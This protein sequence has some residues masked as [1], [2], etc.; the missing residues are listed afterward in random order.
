MIADL[1]SRLTQLVRLLIPWCALTGLLVAQPSLR[2]T[3]PAA[4]TI[5]HPGQSLTVTVEA[6]SARAF[7]QVI[8]IGGDPIGFSRPLTAPPY[9]FTIQ[10]PSKIDPGRY[11]LT[12]DGATAPGQGTMSDPIEI[13]VERPDSPVRLRVEPSILDLSLSQKGY[14]RV[15]G[16][17][18]DGMTTDLTK[19][20]R[21]AFASTTPTVATVQAQGIVTALAPGSAKVIVTCETARVEVQVT[22]IG[23]RR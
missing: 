8:V 1:A 13:V 12:A 14:L 10:I 2:I 5:V 7:Q 9:R 16:E 20:S 3:S 22:V 6:T 17:F 4:G 18:A 23:N 21:V 15:V 19:S 11:L